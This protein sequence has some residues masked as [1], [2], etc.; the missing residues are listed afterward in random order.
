MLYFCDPWKITELSN[1]SNSKLQ[2]FVK[3]SYIIAVFKAGIH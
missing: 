2:I 1:K 3:L